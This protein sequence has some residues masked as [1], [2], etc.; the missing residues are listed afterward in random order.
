M[1]LFKPGE[2]KAL[3]GILPLRINTFVELK[4]PAGFFVS[5]ERIKR[6]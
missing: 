5:G 2:K 4:S 1:G 3:G 6:E